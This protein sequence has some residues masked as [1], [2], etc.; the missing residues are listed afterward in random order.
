MKVRSRCAKVTFPGAQSVAD[1]QMSVSQFEPDEPKSLLQ[2]AQFE[3]DVP[4]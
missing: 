4:K 2:V 1:V 3:P